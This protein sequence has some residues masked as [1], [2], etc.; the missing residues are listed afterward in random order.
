MY[1]KNEI[2]QKKILDFFELMQYYLNNISNLQS[3]IKGKIEELASTESNL[4]EDINLHKLKSSLS[5][6]TRK[7]ENYENIN[8]EIEFK[9]KYSFIFGYSREKIIISILNKYGYNQKQ[10]IQEN[11]QIIGELLTCQHRLYRLINSPGHLKKLS[12]EI[13]RKI[14]QEL[15]W[16][17][18]HNQEENKRIRKAEKAALFMNIIGE[19]EKKACQDHLTSI[20]ELKELN[21]R[22]EY[23]FIT[24]EHNNLVSTTKEKSLMSIG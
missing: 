11:K 2:D 13:K 9:F 22:I 15:T 16:Y 7:L 18:Q 17:C 24:K 8:K 20:V 6:S 4:Q 19:I 1:L 3:H 14:A 5:H 21:E 23:I 12:G 10:L